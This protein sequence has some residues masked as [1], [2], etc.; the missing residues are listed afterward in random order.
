[1]QFSLN[2]IDIL[3]LRIFFWIRLNSRITFIVFGENCLHRVEV[4]QFL[5]VDQN[6]CVH[7]MKSTEEHCL[8]VCL[9]FSRNTKHFLLVLLGWFM[10]WKASDHSAAVLWHATPRISSKQH[11]TF[12]CSSHQAF[13]FPKVEP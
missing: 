4:C 7:A 8:R 11:A 9:Q 3:C 12:L 10:R 5:L 13:F 1:M 6:W 2:I